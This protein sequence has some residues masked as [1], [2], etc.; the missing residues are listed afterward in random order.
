MA[1]TVY[2]VH[3]MKHKL[4]DMQTYQIYSRYDLLTFNT[5]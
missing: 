5:Q 3:T 2:S 1:R 4:N